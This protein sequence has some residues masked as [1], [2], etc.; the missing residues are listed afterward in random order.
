MF[1]TLTGQPRI[2]GSATAWAAGA[3]AKAGSLRSFGVLLD[4]EL[5]NEAKKPF[6]FLV[7]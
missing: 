1:T 5:S 3:L 2:M 6:M 4:K 7:S